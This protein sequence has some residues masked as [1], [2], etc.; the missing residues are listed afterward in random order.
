MR[1]HADSTSP[2]YLRLSFVPAGGQGGAAAQ[3]CSAPAAAWPGAQPRRSCGRCWLC[4]SAST[5]GCAGR[6]FRVCRMGTHMETLQ[7][8][9]IYHHSGCGCCMMLSCVRVNWWIWTFLS[10]VMW[11]WWRPR[12]F[13]TTDA[14][15]AGTEVLQRKCNLLLIQFHLPDGAHTSIIF[16]F[17]CCDIDRMSSGCFG[18]FVESEEIAVDTLIR[19]YKKAIDPWPL[20]VDLLTTSYTWNLGRISTLYRYMRKDNML[21]RFYLRMP[22]YASCLKPHLL[23]SWVG[24][25]WS[26]KG[27]NGVSSHR[28]EQTHG[29]PSTLIPSSWGLGNA[30]VMH[31]TCQA[32]HE[33]CSWLV[34]STS[35]NCFLFIF[36]LLPAR[37]D[38]YELWWSPLTTSLYFFPD[39]VKPPVR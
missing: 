29:K 22:S 26:S 14:C 31:L 7:P 15:L 16:I 5:G 37:L 12:M 32:V 1:I 23:N 24:Q 2:G 11:E 9:I 20:A 4:G 10:Q 27:W 17:F 39:C 13:Q 19:C 28:H 38:N 3:P 21:T 35:F 36:Q 25:D 33:L 34:V 30:H 8:P 6:H 18:A